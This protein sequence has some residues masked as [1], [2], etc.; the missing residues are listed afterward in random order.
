MP[1]IFVQSDAV[2]PCAALSTHC[3]VG[4]ASSSRVARQ[5][6]VGGTPGVT[7]NTPTLEAAAVDFRQI[8]YECEVPAG[9]Y[10]EAGDWTIRMNVTTANADVQWKSAHICRISSGCINQATIGSNTAVNITLNTTGVKTVVISGSAQAPAPGDKV[11]ILLGFTD[12]TSKG[13]ET[14]G[15]TPN[16]NI[17][18]PLKAVL[19]PVGAGVVPN[20]R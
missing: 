3:A 15:L 4:T 7:Q 10:W 14:W 20:P 12:L 17:D 13:T 5:C 18:S 8:W 11:M 1:L 2:G 16:Q 6:T 19:D 9:T